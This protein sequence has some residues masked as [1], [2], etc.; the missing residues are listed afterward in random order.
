MKVLLV[1]KFFFPKGGAETVFFQER[2]FLLEQEVGVVD[3]SMED[4]NNFPSPFSRYFVPHI[5]YYEQNSVR[6]R[7]RNGLSFVHS[8]V[9]VKNIE[10]LIVREQPDIAHLH[11]VYHQLTPSII[12]VLKKHGVKVVMTLHDCKL[13]CPSY[14]ALRSDGRIC[15]RCAGKYFWRAATTNCQGSMAHS[16]LLATEAIYHKWK[17]S[18]DGVDL[19]LLP[20]KFLAKLTEK[21]I[22]PY[23]IKVLHNGIST[24]DYHPNYGSQGY[25]IFLGRLSREKG[26]ATL[27]Q[28]NRMSKTKLSLKVVGTGPL[29]EKLIEEYPEVEFMGFRCGQELKD[30]VSNSAFVVVPSECYENCS[31]V[32]LEAM[33]LG[34]PVIGSRIG[35][36]PEQIEDGINGYLFE[37]GN[38]G[39]LAEKMD[40]L[41]HD[42]E[43]R[44]RLGRAARKKLEQDYSLS[45]HNRQLLN[46]YSDLLRSDP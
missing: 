16:M 44:E 5:D 23:R 9:A 38:V 2:N 39:E 20:S 43:M 30:L 40:I 3:F 41:N 15:E 32:V 28:A 10:Q 25:A 18:Y 26:V 29:S 12:P 34:K 4:K 35:G 17:G 7:V 46:I 31:M 14:L 45:E 36:I 6:Q 13:I 1:N 21:R 42:D 22:S 19:F 11:N 37:M 24:G 8:S 27:L 33:A